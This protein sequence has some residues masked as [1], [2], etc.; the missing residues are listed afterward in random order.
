MATF[1][2]GADTG[3]TDLGDVTPRAPMKQAV[4]I[5]PLSAGE[6]YGAR[7]RTLKSR[8]TLTLAGDADVG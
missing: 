5:L 6:R 7:H 3:A 1:T 8:K 2:L 4:R